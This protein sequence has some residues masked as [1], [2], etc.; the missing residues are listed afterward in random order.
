MYSYC[1]VNDIS[2][3][4]GALSSSCIQNNG[5]YFLSVSYPEIHKL[6]HATVSPSSIT[7]YLH[8]FTPA[9]AVE[10]IKLVPYVCLSVGQRS[11]G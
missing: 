2:S 5:K 10:G 11:H 4:P 1:L 6:C 9:S 3:S 7:Y 8:L